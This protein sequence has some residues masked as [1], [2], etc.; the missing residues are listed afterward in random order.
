[1][2]C[3][4]LLLIVIQ[5]LRPWPAWAQ[6]TMSLDP[7]E[8][9]DRYV[10]P[11][12][13]LDVFS[14]VILVARGDDIV[15]SRAYGLAERE[16]DIPVAVDHA[17]RIASIS[18]SFTR[19]LAGRLSERGILRLDDPLARWLPEFPAADRITIRH[20][21]DHRAGVPSINS[22][23]FDEE[24]FAPNSLAALVDSIAR[25]PLDFEPGTSESYSNG[26]YAVLA[27]ALEKA[28]GTPYPELLDA[29]VLRPLALERTR[30]EREGEIVPRLARGYE[31]SPDGFGRMRHAPFQQMMTK[32]GGGS[33]VST[34]H[35]LHRWA[36]ALGR[37]PILSAS[38]WAELFPEANI[39]LTGRNPG[40]NAA[41]LR[42]GEWI[43]VVLA[44]NYA[45][46]AAAD[47]AEAAIRL[48]SGE[49]AETL[50][51]VAPIAPLAEELVP[52]AGTYALP[53]GILPLPPGTK[54][55]IERSGDELVAS[56]A[57]VPVDVLVPQGNRTFLL[58]M[59][60]STATFDEPVDG[61]SEGFEVRALYRDAA[62]RVER[63]A[64]ERP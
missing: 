27:L 62:F 45:A 47:V 24:A 13:D 54:V 30:H 38:T 31:P 39:A 40:Y 26:G 10:A 23:P 29:E 34:A 28:A 11:L 53:D 2:R 3:F 7:A 58:R 55:E 64:G 36:S 19:V 57:G 59:L 46:G 52:L 20:L 43:A 32:T 51:V 16:F 44:N 6:G 12:V 22:L 49:P 5:L 33:L 1:M 60:W 25:M 48:A 14:G 50:P 18:K 15:V 4:L 63:V 56:L 17:F 35:D 9:I 41:L 37:D 42:D 21:L 8:S 61:R